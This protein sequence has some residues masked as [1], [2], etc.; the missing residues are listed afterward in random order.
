MTAIGLPLQGLLLEFQ[1]PP[2]CFSS[3]P[4]P[5]QIICLSSEAWPEEVCFASAHL[6]NHWGFPLNFCSLL[7]ASSCQPSWWLDLVHILEILQGDL[8]GWV[9]GKWLWPTGGNIRWC[10]GEGLSYST[11]EGL[12]GREEKASDPKGQEMGLSSGA[13]TIYALAHPPCG[14]QLSICKMQMISKGLF[15]ESTVT[16]H[17]GRGPIPECCFSSHWFC[18]LYPR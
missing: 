2:P 9:G 7:R 5:A 15:Y 10:G 3:S 11:C 8:G 12:P 1:A 13:D 14:P 16:F 4:E 17:L 18:K 6:G